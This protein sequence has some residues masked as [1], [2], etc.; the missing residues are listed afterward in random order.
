M[1]I[2]RSRFRLVSVIL[3]LFSLGVA[4]MGALLIPLAAAQESSTPAPQVD[5][6]TTDWLAQ[7]AVTDTT[8]V[9]VTFHDTAMQAEADAAQAIPDRAT[10]RAQVYA[11]LQRQAEEHD[12][13][14]RAF[15]DTNGL[16]AD[17][18]V[19]IASN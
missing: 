13:A 6:L 7:A 1:I 8:T 3:M 15:L 12:I 11:A 14:L 18:Q 4:T 2:F 10:R 5:V 16:D 9:L 19:F 17:Y